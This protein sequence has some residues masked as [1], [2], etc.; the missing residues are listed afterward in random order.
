MSND[1]APM[2]RKMLESLESAERNAKYWINAGR[3]HPDKAEAVLCVEQAANAWKNLAYAFARAAAPEVD[4]EAVRLLR[5]VA[6]ALQNMGDY[7]S[8]GMA[9]TD[10][11]TPTAEDDAAVHAIAKESA[12]AVIAARQFLTAGQAAGEGMPV[13]AGAIWVNQ[14]IGRAGPFVLKDEYD[15]LYDLV[16]QSR[17][18]NQAMRKRLTC[19]DALSDW[20]DI[21][22]EAFFVEHKVGQEIDRLQR[23]NAGLMS[24]I[25]DAWS[26]FG[27]A[28]ESDPSLLGEHARAVRSALT[29]ARAA[30]PE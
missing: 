14:P 27:A 24:A 20:I 16:S 5:V 18:E 2:T 28:R 13:K 10:G 3:E 4:A 15:K 7:W 9:K 25:G 8:Y 26:A 21:G 23:E 29:A 1:T 6:D 11:A 22:G 12:D 30:S 19:G 17:R